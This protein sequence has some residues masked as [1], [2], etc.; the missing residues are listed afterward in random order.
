MSLVFALEKNG[1]KREARFS[2]NIFWGG[3]FRD[4]VVYGRL[5]PK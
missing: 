2:E 5:A 1:V 4:T 3:E